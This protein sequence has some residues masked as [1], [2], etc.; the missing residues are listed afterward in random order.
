MTIQWGTPNGQVDVYNVVFNCSSP[1]EDSKM[2][3]NYKLTVSDPSAAV[4]GLDPGSKC[5]VSIVTQINASSG[6][7]ALLGNA[8]IKM[9]T[10]TSNETGM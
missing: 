2:E 6:L 9:L 7:S 3:P 8:T 4:T 10:E 1:N 5:S